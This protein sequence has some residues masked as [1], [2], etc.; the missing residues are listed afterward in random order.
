MQDWLF[1][2]GHDEIW[3]SANPAP[4]LRA[5]G[6]YRRLGW[7]ADGSHRPGDEK[8]TMPRPTAGVS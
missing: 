2:E 6:L 3:L 1:A 7:R 8:L 4:S 5:H